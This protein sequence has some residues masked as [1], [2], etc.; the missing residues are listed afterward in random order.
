MYVKQVCPAIDR[1]RVSDIPLAVKSKIAAGELAAGVALLERYVIDGMRRQV[2]HHL[3]VL[4]PAYLSQQ[5][6]RPRA[7]PTQLSPQRICA[8]RLQSALTLSTNNC[9]LTAP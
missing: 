1:R 9:L 5:L 8:T 3:C 7:A 6:Q 4:P 2:D